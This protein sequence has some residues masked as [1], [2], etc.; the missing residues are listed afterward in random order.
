MHFKHEIQEV[1]KCWVKIAQREDMM[2]NTKNEVISGRLGLTTGEKDL[3]RCQGRIIGDHLIYLPTNSDL[4]KLVIQDAH[5]G[6]LHGII[7]L[8]MAKVR[9]K[10]WKK[11]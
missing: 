4:T 2:S 5:L 6:T 9:E 7:G 11:G 1:E 10:W 3:L 8:T